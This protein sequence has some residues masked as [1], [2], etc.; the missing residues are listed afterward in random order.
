MAYD[1]RLTVKI[2]S[3]YYMKKLNQETIASRL[4][5]SRQSIGRHLRY[6]EER[7]I[8][9][10]A[11]HSPLLYVAEIEARLESEYGLHEAIVVSVPLQSDDVIRQAIGAA[12]ADFLG[13]RVKANDCLGVSWSSTVLACARRLPHRQVEGFRVVQL[14]G[15]MD[16]VNYSTRAESIIETVCLAFSGAPVTLAV[17]MLVDSQAIRRSLLADSRVQTAF[18]AAQRAN[19]ALFGIG[20]ISQ[21]SSLFKAGYMDQILLD[22]LLAR[23]AAG[24]ICGHFFDAK[25][26]ICDGALEQRLLAVSRENLRGKELSI[27]LAGGAGKAPAV[28]AALKGGWCNVLVTDE[29]TA[30]QVLA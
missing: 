5:L 26:E 2:A 9:E 14:N 1:D 24:D 18:E 28:K 22:R 15:S 27:G 4:G 30:G 11:I 10:H 3:L 17:P 12:A 19:L 6:A 16:K 23:G 29:I 25:G 8:V 7:G 21:D 20:A 13:R